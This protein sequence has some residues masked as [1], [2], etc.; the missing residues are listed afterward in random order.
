MPLHFLVFSL[1]QFCEAGAMTF[2]LFSSNEEISSEG[3]SDLSKVVQLLIGEARAQS[4]VQPADCACGRWASHASVLMPSSRHPSPSVL[5]IWKHLKSPE[6]TAASRFLASAHPPSARDSLPRPD[7]G[8][9]FP[10]GPSGP[11]HVSRASLHHHRACPSPRE[12]VNSQRT[13]A[14]CAASRIQ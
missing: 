6:A 5:V 8:P 7:A 3:L 1:P 11:S 14:H 4:Q 9:T 12:P 10:A 13:E 2:T